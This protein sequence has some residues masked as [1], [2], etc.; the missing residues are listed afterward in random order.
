MPLE[1]II[2]GQ[3]VARVFSSAY[4]LLHVADALGG[5]V[6]LAYF[7]LIVVAVGIDGRIVLGHSAVIAVQGVGDLVYPLCGELVV[8]ALQ[9][10]G[11]LPLL[12]RQV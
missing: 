4:A 6:E 1:G 7:L 3:V 2:G 8:V 9:Q 11:K 10:G 5:L 12:G